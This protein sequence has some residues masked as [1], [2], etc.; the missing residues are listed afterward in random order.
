MVV[1]VEL[2]KLVKQKRTTRARRKTKD[3]IQETLEARKGPRQVNKHGNKQIMMSMRKESGK[4]LSE[5]EVLK[6]CADFYR[7]N[8]TKTLSTPESTMKS[9]Q[10]TKEITKIT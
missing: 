3:L 6:V 7:S 5:R 9:S 8:N 10:D 1:Y 4:I 2:N